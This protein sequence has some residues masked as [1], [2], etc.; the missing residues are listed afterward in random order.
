VPPT[1]DF[2]T[3]G[4]TGRLGEQAHFFE[5]LGD[6]VAP[7]VELDD[8]RAFAGA[9]TFKHAGALRKV[10][11]KEENRKYRQRREGRFDTARRRSGEP[12]KQLLTGG[13]A[14]LSPSC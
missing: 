3:E 2:G 10:K 7:E 9:G 4:G 14:S 12:V 1:I 8:H 6:V 11:T 5:L 13:H